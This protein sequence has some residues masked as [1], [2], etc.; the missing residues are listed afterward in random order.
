MQGVEITLLKMIKVNIT[1]LQAV[2]LFVFVRS[3]LT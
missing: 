1:Y 2:G 3:L